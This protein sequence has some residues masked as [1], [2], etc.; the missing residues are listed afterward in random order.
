MTDFEVGER[1]VWPGQ[2]L[3]RIDGVEEKNGELASEDYQG[4]T[5]YILPED[6]DGKPARVSARAAACAA[7]HRPP[8]DL[9]RLGKA[10]IA[11][12]L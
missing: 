7:Q 4:V 8:S 11:A 5:V 3:G 9:Q 2:G 1:V 10:H 12:P 6:E